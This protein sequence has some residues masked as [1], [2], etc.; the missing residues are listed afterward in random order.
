MTEHRDE[1]AIGIAR[2]DDDLWNLLAAA[3]TEVRPRPAGIRRLVDAVA[4]REVGP[5]QP[6]A[7]VEHIRLRRDAGGGFR[8]SAAHRADVAPVE[9]GEDRW[10]ECGGLLGAEAMGESAARGEDGDDGEDSAH[11][12]SLHDA[13][14]QC[15]A[16]ASK[17]QKTMVLL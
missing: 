17:R 8:A 5:L 16:G 13:L 1:Q 6:L 9:R 15:V 2:I 10:I 11:G 4:S 12:S 3:E 7:D 14:R